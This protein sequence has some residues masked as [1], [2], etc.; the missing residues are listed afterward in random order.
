MGYCS[1]CGVSYYVSHGHV[2]T[3]RAAVYPMNDTRL[4][5][6]L[7]LLREIAAN[8]KPVA[9]PSPSPQVAVAAQVPRAAIARLREHYHPRSNTTSYMPGTFKGEDRRN[10]DWDALDEWLSS[11]AAPSE[12]KEAEEMGCTDGYMLATAACSSAQPSARAEGAG[13][14]SS[15]HSD[16]PTG[17]PGYCFDIDGEWWHKPGSCRYCRPATIP[18]PAALPAPAPK[19]ASAEVEEAWEIVEGQMSDYRDLRYGY[20][21]TTR[22]EHID[23]ALATL[24]RHVG[25]KG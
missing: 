14:E 6:A 2:C 10:A 25:G 19:A 17:A 20:L 1:N 22:V 12:A 8:T 4:D 5:E 16:T 11:A 15:G 7:A 13:A 21:D 9:A 24:R 23:A 18:K 3:Y